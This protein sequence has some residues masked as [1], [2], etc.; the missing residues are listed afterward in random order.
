MWICITFFQQKNFVR[1]VKLIFTHTVGIFQILFQILVIKTVPLIILLHG[2]SKLEKRSMYNNHRH[3]WSC[4][5]CQGPHQLFLPKLHEDTANPNMKL[6]ENDEHSYHELHLELWSWDR[7]PRWAPYGPAKTGK[8][9]FHMMHWVVV[10]ASGMPFC[11][12][13]L[14]S[15]KL[16]EART[17]TSCAQGAHQW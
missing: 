1:Q 5:G 10:L 8:Y 16:D 11:S 7:C 14:Q 2:E 9:S 6:N 4:C 17:R 12:R 13:P 15:Q 3:S